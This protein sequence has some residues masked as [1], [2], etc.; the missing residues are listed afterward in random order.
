M[1]KPSRGM[2]NSFLPGTV[3]REPWSLALSSFGISQVMPSLESQYLWKM[4]ECFGHVSPSHYIEI[5]NQT[6]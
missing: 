5:P 1:F 6:M 2:V 3:A 4:T